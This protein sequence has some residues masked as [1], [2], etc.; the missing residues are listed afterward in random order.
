MIMENIIEMYHLKVKTE[1]PVDMERTERKK[2]IL[3]PGYIRLTIIIFLCV[4][5]AASGYYW[6]NLEYRQ[7]LIDKSVPV[8]SYVCSPN[9]SYKVFYIQNDIYPEE[10]LG[11]NQL[12]ISKF[13]EHI[14]SSFSCEFHGDRPAEIKGTYSATAYLKGA[15]RGITQD[16]ILWTKE[17]ELLPE[18]AFSRNGNE[19]TID[20]ELPIELNDIISYAEHANTTLNISSNVQLEII[21]DFSI[22]SVTDKGTVTKEFSPSL[23][24]PIANDYFEI[25]KNIPEQKPESID[26]R[27][28][29]ISPS[30]ERN[31][32]TV[33]II[34][35]II[36]IALLFVLIFTRKIALDP[37]YLKADKLFK[38]YG[39][40]IVVSDSDILYGSREII[41]VSTIDGLIKTA[42]DLGKPILYKNNSIFEEN[43][44][45][46][47]VDDKINY[48]FRLKKL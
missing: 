46:F 42:D 34:A 41:E 17:F 23:S 10:S 18:R 45:L 9:V 22:Q 25:T 40:H 13:V 19:V 1:E 3:I 31:R 43:C 11:E 6:Y 4:L 20:Y 12:Y 44:R 7:K 33:W 16:R 28:Q 8:Y 36:C 30:Y 26:E 37:Y 15:L 14:Q 39:A 2:H 47:V 35:A 32:L 48:I 24:F 27:V 5:F 29:S 21:Y 38:K